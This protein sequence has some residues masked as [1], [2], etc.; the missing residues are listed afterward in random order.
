[1]GNSDF[2]Q[3]LD[4]I[5]KNIDNQPSLDEL[6]PVHKAPE[7][8]DFGKYLWGAFGAI[9]GLIAMTM[10]IFANINY[11]KASTDTETPQMFLIVIGSAATGLFSMAI[12]AVLL[13]LSFIFLSEY[14]GLRMM[15]YGYLLG[16]V[17]ASVALGMT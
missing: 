15:V 12:F 13:G 1:M 7:S 11:D 9:W 14:R 6:K 2:Q 16:I 10:V 17:V 3:R 4:R 8:S 5:A